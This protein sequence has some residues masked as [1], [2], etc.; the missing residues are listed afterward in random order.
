MH[1]LDHQTASAP[2]FQNSDYSTQTSSRLRYD[3]LPPDVQGRL[4]ADVNQELIDYNTQR[5]IADLS[6]QPS[7]TRVNQSKRNLPSL[8]NILISFRVLMSQ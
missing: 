6:T 3:D 1:E 2:V 5:A 4:L 7:S 8:L